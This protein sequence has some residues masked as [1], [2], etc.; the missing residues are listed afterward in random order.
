MYLLCEVDNGNL[1]S[2]LRWMNGLLMD[3]EGNDLEC[4]GWDFYR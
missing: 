1:T 4:L 3:V 2:L